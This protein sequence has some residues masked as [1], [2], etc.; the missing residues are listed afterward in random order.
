MAAAE[1]D[2]CLSPMAPRADV[3]ALSRGQRVVWRNGRSGREGRVKIV[4]DARRL[5]A[6]FE[7]LEPFV[8]QW[9]LTGTQE[10]HACRETAS[11]G[12]IRRFYDT[13]LARAPAAIAFLD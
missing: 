8:D 9:S 2:D 11:I 5:P 10:R 12:D 7:D 4:D 1:P 3:A 13:M 6:G